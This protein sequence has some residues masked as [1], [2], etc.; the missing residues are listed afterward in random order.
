MNWY[1]FCL[2]NFNAGIANADNLKIYVVK[3]KITADQYK[4]IT[5]IDYIAS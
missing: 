4:T 2:N 1:N 3:S 5:G